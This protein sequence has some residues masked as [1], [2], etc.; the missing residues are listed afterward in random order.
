MPILHVPSV[1]PPALAS[2]SAHLSVSLPAAVLLACCRPAH[3]LPLCL[4]TAALLTSPR[5]VLLLQVEA[6]A[7]FPPTFLYTQSWEDPLTDEP[8]L[9]VRTLNPKP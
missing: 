4:P 7:L 2:H 8:H 9:Q 5:A 1:Q 3:G 6:P